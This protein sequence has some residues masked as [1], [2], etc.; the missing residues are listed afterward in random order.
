MQKVF[1]IGTVCCSLL[2]F[3]SLIHAAMAD[4][5]PKQAAGAAIAV[6]LAV[7]PYVLSRS[8]SELGKLDSTESPSVEEE[9]E[10]AS[11]SDGKALLIVVTVAAV[12]FAAIAFLS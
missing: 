1:W 12:G 6:G 8:M 11:D 10:K 3:G 2:A 5:S 7:I 9:S 4:S